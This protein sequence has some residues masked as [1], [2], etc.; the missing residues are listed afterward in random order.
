MLGI[1]PAVVADLAPPIQNR[2]QRLT[3]LAVEAA[4]VLVDGGA[5]DHVA[6]GQLNIARGCA[7]HAAP[8]SLWSQQ[9]SHMPRCRERG[10]INGL[11]QRVQKSCISAASGGTVV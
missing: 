4:A 7:G 6:D 5:V 1:A 11:P 2:K 9:L 8:S 3:A 10:A